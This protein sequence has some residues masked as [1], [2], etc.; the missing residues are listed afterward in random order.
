[1]LDTIAL[2]E[3]TFCGGIR[4]SRGDYIVGDDSGVVVIPPSCVEEVIA[5]AQQVFDAEEE[6]ARRI[7]QGGKVRS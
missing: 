5:L 1:V 2:D 3:P 4:V 7:R 6:V